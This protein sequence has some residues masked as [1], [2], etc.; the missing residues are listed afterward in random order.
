MDENEG[1]EK[2][3]KPNQQLTSLFFLKTKKIGPALDD[4]A[5]AHLGP[6]PGPNAHPFLQLL[7]LGDR[8]D[9]LLAVGPPLLLVTEHRTQLSE[10]P[11]FTLR[12]LASHRQRRHGRLRVELEP[13]QSAHRGLGHGEGLRGVAGDGSREDREPGVDRRGLGGRPEADG[14]ERLGLVLLGGL[15]LKYAFFKS[16]ACF[17]YTYAVLFF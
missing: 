10:S 2:K 5:Q 11:A 17:I 3:K 9:L 12:R 16:F 6:H 7:L 13:G 8:L 15:R 14:R 4:D 1:R